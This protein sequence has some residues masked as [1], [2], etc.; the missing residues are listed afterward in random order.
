MKSKFATQRLLLTSLTVDKD[1][2]ILKLVNT[3]GWLRFIGDRNI[4]S[5]NDAKDYISKINQN[6]IFK[7]WVVELLKEQ[8]PIG[9]ITFIKRD[10]LEFHDIGFAFLPEYAKSG[11]AFE[12]TSVILNYLVG[13]RITEQLLATTVP[14]NTNSIRLLTKL[15]FVENQEIEVDDKKLLVY[16]LYL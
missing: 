6:P 10:Y 12:A 3:Q 16:R 2:F 14:D 11:Y 5:A 1:E 4:H 9:I 15:G 13:E 8:I 7:Y